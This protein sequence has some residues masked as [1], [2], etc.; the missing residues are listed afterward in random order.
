MTIHEQKLVADLISLVA[1]AVATDTIPEAIEYMV[2]YYPE[3]EL[4]DHTYAVLTKIQQQSK[5]KGISI[6]IT[7]LTI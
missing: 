5:P 6:N 3:D 7:N 2:N 1:N 4:T